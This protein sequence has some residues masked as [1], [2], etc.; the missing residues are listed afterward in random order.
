MKF[1]KL[2]VDSH[3]YFWS[4]ILNA[5]VWQQIEQAFHFYPWPL[6]SFIMI[7]LEI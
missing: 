6:I 3:N 4:Q 5:M 7:S 2:S 1:W